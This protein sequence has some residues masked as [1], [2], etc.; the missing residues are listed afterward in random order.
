M[1]PKGA[2]LFASIVV[3]VSGAILL[4]GAK[5]LFNANASTSWPT[6]QGRVI[7]SS[8]DSKREDKQR[9]TYHA[10]VLYEFSVAGQN[11]SS[12]DITFVEYGSTNP[13]HARRSV[14]QYPAGSTVTVYY[15]PTD[16]D[17]SVLE[18]G[19]SGQTIFLPSF[20]AVF[21]FAGLAMFIF[22]PR[23]IQKHERQNL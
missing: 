2:R 7:S 11:H 18:P 9:T 21:L 13:A 8:I 10:E 22:V 14:N 23:A 15:S 19:I 17:T 4:Y 6:T 3:F 16:P 20:G 12:N 1:T 5:L